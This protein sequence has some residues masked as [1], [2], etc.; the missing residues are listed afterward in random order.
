MNRL[1]LVG[2]GRMGQLVEQLAPS[3][4]FA[5]A[6]LSIAQALVGVVAPELAP[7]PLGIRL[8]LRHVFVA[9]HRPQA[10]LEVPRLPQIAIA[11]VE[12]GPHI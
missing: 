3:Y 4:G 6:G 11:P 5:L 1:L 2:H 10:A 12:V 8:E 7:H 9:Q